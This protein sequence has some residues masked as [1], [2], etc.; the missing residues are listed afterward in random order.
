MNAGKAQPALTAP[1]RKPA[2]FRKQVPACCAAQTCNARRAGHWRAPGRVK[3]RGLRSWRF[4]RRTQ[5]EALRPAFATP[6]ASARTVSTEPT[7]GPSSRVSSVS[8]TRPRRRPLLLPS[9]DVYR[10]GLDGWAAGRARPHHR[11]CRSRWEAALSHRPA[12]Q[13]CEGRPGRHRWA[14][15]ALSP[16]EPA[17]DDAGRWPAIGAGTNP[18]TTVGQRV[19]CLVC[20]ISAAPGG[21]RRAFMIF[22]R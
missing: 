1:I 12:S 4:A 20:S 17:W 21:G 9:A 7:A 18:P 5:I 11:P 10:Y 22:P 19:P 14:R 3:A 2:S 16:A 8:T 13:S 6:R 15:R